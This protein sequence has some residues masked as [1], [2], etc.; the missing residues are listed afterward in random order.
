V[1]YE[2]IESF[3]T[4]TIGVMDT[5]LQSDISKGTIGLVRSEE[6]TGEVAI[7]IGIREDSEGS[8]ILNMNRETAM[9][10]CSVMNGEPFDVLTAFG[11]D[12][13]AELANMIAGNATSV[14]NDRGFSFAL[15]TPA[16]VARE[17][18]AGRTLSRELFQIPLF[19]D[20]GEIT[21]NIAMR[22]N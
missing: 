2:F 3:V 19:T 13:L 8:I 4:S 20:C 9:R 15:S 10:I 18:I 7:V 14:L 12:S 21:M 11:M 16:V 6:L 5:V 1:R 22:T 17:E